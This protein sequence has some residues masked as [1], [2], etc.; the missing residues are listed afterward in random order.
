MAREHAQGSHE[1]AL[2]LNVADR[3]PSPPLAGI[4]FED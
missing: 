2:G 3:A 4:P 1:D